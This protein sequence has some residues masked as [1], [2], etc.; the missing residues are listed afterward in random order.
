MTEKCRLCHDPTHVAHRLP[1]RAADHSSG[2]PETTIWFDTPAK[3]FTE[4]VRWETAVWA[5]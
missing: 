1:S 4:S 5:Q 3:N 2:T